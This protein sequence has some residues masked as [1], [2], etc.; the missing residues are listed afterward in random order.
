M[1][2]PTQ[3]IRGWSIVNLLG[4]VQGVSGPGPFGDVALARLVAVEVL[5]SKAVM[6]GANGIVNLRLLHDGIGDVVAHG[7]AVVAIPIV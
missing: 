3:V 7:D 5:V 1:C 4:P 6:L 2:A